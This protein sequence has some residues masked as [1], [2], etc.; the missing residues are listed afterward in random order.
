[1]ALVLALAQRNNKEMKGVKA[2]HKVREREMIGQDRKGKIRSGKERKKICLPCGKKNTNYIERDLI[3]KS[4]YLAVNC[5]P[6]SEPKL[7]HRLR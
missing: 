6:C 4:I 1:M 3:L 7:P 2:G 5:S